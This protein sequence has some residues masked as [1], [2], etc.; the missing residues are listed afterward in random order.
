MLSVMERLTW[1]LSQKEVGNLKLGPQQ[2]QDNALAL[3]TREIKPFTCTV[4]AEPVTVR[5]EGI[6]EKLGDIVL[7]FSGGTPQLPGENPMFLTIQV[8]L[9]VN[10]TSR[11]R[12]DSLADV[13]LVP[14]QPRFTALEAP[15]L[16]PGTPLRP[17][18]VIFYA[19][20][21]F[22]P[23][24]LG[25][26]RLRIVALRGNA[27][28]LGV[29]GTLIESQ[30]TASVSV[31]SPGSGPVPVYDPTHVV[32]K[33]RSG[34]SFRVCEDP[35]VVRSVPGLNG[36]LL[37]EPRADV[38]P[39]TFHIAFKEVYVG[40][41]STKDQELSTQR[42]AGADHGVRLLARFNNVPTGVRLYVTDRDVVLGVNYDDLEG[43]PVKALLVD[44]K[45]FM[46]EGG[47]TP[48]VS[49]AARRV[50]I[51]ELE[52]D[53]T[54]SAVATWEWVDSSLSLRREPSE[55]FF[56]VFVALP[57]RAAVPGT[58][59]VNGSFAPLSTVVMFESR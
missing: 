45:R 54:G 36:Q 30:I 14:E 52:I 22:T 33:V 29:S 23:G 1:H 21:I 12:D 47:E 51:A 16:R 5:A 35:P 55:V 10:L 50:S 46:G 15:T 43:Y 27:N 13:F 34:L 28:Q 56:G 53:S 49:E 20:P 57:P 2:A 18:S 42:I 59:T 9:N 24:V 38:A 11:L 17:N 25:A 44:A 32:A 7:S 31:S 19:V 8:Y 39:P 3:Y 6:S 58:A 4:S 37:V 48:S 41:F 26:L 40:S